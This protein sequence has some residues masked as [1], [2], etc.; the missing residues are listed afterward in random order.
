M[1]TSSVIGLLEDER[2]KL[3]QDLK[4][5]TLSDAE[6][7]AMHGRLSVI[8][9]QLGALPT[10]AL[11]PPAAATPFSEERLLL[12]IREALDA[13]RLPVAAA[14]FP[15]EG[16]LPIIRQALDESLPQAMAKYE[17]LRFMK[18]R[19][20]ICDAASA[21][22]AKRQ[23]D[24]EWVQ[25]RQD[26]FGLSCLVTATPVPRGTQS[27]GDTPGKFKMAHIVQ[28]KI[29]NSPH[30]M[31]FFDMTVDELD[32][33]G[34]ILL[35]RRDVEEAFDR[36][37]FCFLPAAAGCFEVV[38]MPPRPPTA[39]TQRPHD[40]H[41]LVFMPEFVSRRMLMIQ[42]M[43][44]HRGRMCHFDA[45]RWTGIGPRPGSTAPLVTKWLDGQLAQTQQ[46]TSGHE[47][48]DDA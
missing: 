10:P 41:G 38:W 1:S 22:S 24:T 4:K 16:L 19:Y 9:G 13:Y 14:P 3:R 5:P 43:D 47:D 23:N 48:D 37:D 40:Y 33:D 28:R 30:L 7:I 27:S 36:L 42:A 2:E 8:H 11:P 29:K 25:R 45:T 34:N 46:R 18:S 31:Q 15:V 21:S 35:L 12:I 6:R 26:A 32:S 20:G 44:A 39:A 17:L